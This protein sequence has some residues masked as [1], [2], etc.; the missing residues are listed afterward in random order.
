MV[1]PG[2]TGVLDP[3]SFLF[4]PCYWSMQGPKLT[5][6]NLVTDLTHAISVGGSLPISRLHG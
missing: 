1:V 3:E 5:L 4:E 6:Q 2:V